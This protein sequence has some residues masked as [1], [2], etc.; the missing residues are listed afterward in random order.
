MV[1]HAARR[2]AVYTT[3]YPAARR[4]VRQWYSSLLEQTDR[5]FELWVG[6]DGITPGEVMN[7][8]GEDP[9][10]R[11]ISAEPGETPSGLRA[12]AVRQIGEAFADV[13]LVDCDDWMYPDRVASARAQLAR[14]DVVACALRIV[15]E[16][17]QDTR[18]VFGLTG[19]S[20]WRDLL[21]RYNVFGFSNSAYRAEVL[22]SLPAAS[23]GGPAID[24]S[25]ATRAWCAGASLHFDSGPPQMA[26]RQYA[27]NVARVLPPFSPADVAGATGVVRAHYEDLLD[28]SVALPDAY[29]SRLEQARGRLERFRVDVVERPDRLERYVSDLNRIEPRYVWWWCVAHPELEGQ[30]TS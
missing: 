1:G 9:G 17:G 5:D 15:D 12:R 2:L 14:H 21:P 26:Y 24:W 3:I 27:G 11:W 10:A 7:L 13:V 22:R 25:L 4:F 6:L 8:V 23:S 28:Q 16:A 19:P 29:R 30:W 18:L 20:D